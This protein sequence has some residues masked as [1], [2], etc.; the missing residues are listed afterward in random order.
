MAADRR[1]E[2]PW[3]AVFELRNGWN[4]ETVLFC[5][6][7]A[8]LG[9]IGFVVP[10]WGVSIFL[11]V[12]AGT[13]ILSGASAIRGNWFFR[14]G[15]EGPVIR[16]TTFRGEHRVQLPWDQVGA[17]VVWKLH[18]SRWI[19]VIPRPGASLPGDDAPAWLRGIARMGAGDAARMCTPAHGVRIDLPRLAKLLGEFAPHVALVDHSGRRTVVHRQGFDA[20]PLG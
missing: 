19:G 5:A 6:F 20:D 7:V 15:S 3:E 10:G 4:P 12:M 16:S 2:H 11:W 17:I 13:G 9:G 14:A 18:H 1:H 8:V